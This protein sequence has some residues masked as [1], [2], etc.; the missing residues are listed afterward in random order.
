MAIPAVV[1]QARLLDDHYAAQR[2]RASD[3]HANGSH[4]ALIGVRLIYA[5]HAVSAQT[6]PR[7]FR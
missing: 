5:T 4:R 3:I 7:K 6:P 2:W 1:L